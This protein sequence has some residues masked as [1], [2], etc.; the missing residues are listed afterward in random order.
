MAKFDIARQGVGAMFMSATAVLLAACG[1]GG[2]DGGTSAVNPPAPVSHA[3][4]VTVAVPALPDRQYWLAYQDGDGAWALAKKTDKGFSFD[5][6]NQEGK[7]AVVLVDEPTPANIYSWGPRITGFYFTRA[8]VPEIDLYAP[9]PDPISVRYSI[10]GG[11]ADGSSRTCAVGI[12]TVLQIL[13]TCSGSNYR[14]ALGAGTGDVFVTS[15]DSTGVADWLIA[16]RDQPLTNG[17]NLSFDFTTAVKLGP[18]Q[19]AQVIDDAKLPGESYGHSA[20]LVTLTG[21]ARLGQSAGGSVS[22]ALL[23]ESAQR[24]TDYYSVTAL[25]SLDQGDSQAYRIATYRSKSGPAQS[26]KL[27][28]SVKPITFGIAPG[29]ATARPVLSW[30]PLEGSLMSN[31]HASTDNPDQPEWDLTFSTGWTKG[32]K[33]ATYAFP[34]LG[35]LGWK[36]SW[37]MPRPGQTKLNYVERYTSNADKRFYLFLGREKY[38]DETNWYSSVSTT[39]T[40]P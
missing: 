11:P 37:Y 40:M 32:G 4:P 20:Q 14:A 3:G 24:A 30:S 29:S 2:G 12:G 34:D 10:A 7:Y 1:G 19:T 33:Q 26:L 21:R 13:P 15:L 16:K 25:A 28:R 38:A 18:V 23:P 27:P 31:V 36:A 35:A 8:E 5:V 22:Y 6:A 9:T 17:L 39:V